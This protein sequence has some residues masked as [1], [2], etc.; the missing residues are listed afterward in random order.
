MVCA[1]LVKRQKKTIVITSNKIV[2]IRIT[3]RYKSPSRI[4][5][6]ISTGFGT[7]YSSEGGDFGGSTE[8]TLVDLRIY[9]NPAGVFNGLSDIPLIWRGRSKRH[10]FAICKFEDYFK[11]FIDTTGESSSFVILPC[12]TTSS[13]G[14]NRGVSPYF[15]SHFNPRPYPQM[16]V[17]SDMPG[18]GQ[19]SQTDC[20][21]VPLID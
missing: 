13:A 20:R 2:F 12:K 4:I 6:A 17:G 11:S 1:S 7:G 18:N 9:S 14:A 3:I 21:V 15:R 8:S 19:T 10:N 5:A 16:G